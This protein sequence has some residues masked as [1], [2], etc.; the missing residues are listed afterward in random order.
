MISNFHFNFIIFCVIF[1]LLTLVVLFSTA[2]RAAVVAKLVKVGISSLS[3]Y[4][5]IKSSISS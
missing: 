4:F 1:S 2:V 5:S 3:S